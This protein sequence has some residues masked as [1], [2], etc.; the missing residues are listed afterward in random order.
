MRWRCRKAGAF[1]K[2]IILIVGDDSG[3]LQIDDDIFHRVKMDSSMR[4]LAQ[5][6]TRMTNHIRWRD[7]AKTKSE[8]NAPWCD[9]RL[10]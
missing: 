1:D 5:S 3:S 6:S 8:L 10:G 2:L 9:L 7:R 4:D